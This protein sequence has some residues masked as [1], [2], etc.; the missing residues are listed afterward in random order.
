MATVAT[1]SVNF[2]QITN[3]TTD[4]A[5]TPTS[6]K[7]IN[8][9]TLAQ[10]CLGTTATSN[11]NYLGGFVKKTGDTMTGMLTLP[12]T[13]PSTDNHSTRKAYVDGRI[14]SLS[15]SVNDTSNGFVRIAGSTMTGMLTLPDISPTVNN[16]A[17]RKLYV[18]TR[19]SSLCASITDTSNGLGRLYLPLTGGTMSG[20]INMGNKNISNLAT[21]QQTNDAATKGYVDTQITGG[22]EG[23]AAIS[24]VNNQDNLRVLKAGDTMTGRLTINYNNPTICFQDTDHRSAFTH[25]NSDYFYILRG[26]D[27]STSWDAG[28]NGRHPLYLNLENGDATVSRDLYVGFNNGSSWE[29]RK[30]ATEQYVQDVANTRLSIAGGTMTGFVTLHAKPTAAKHAATKDYVDDVLTNSY[31]TIAYVNQ[32]DGQRVAKSGDTMSGNLVIRNSAPTIYFQDTDNKS[33]WI[34]INSNIFYIG[35][36]PNDTTRIDGADTINGR[37][38]FTVNLGNGNAV[39][40]G[41]VTAY[42][43]ERLKKNIKPIEN[44]LDKTL[45]L[46]GVTFERV[47]SG[48]KGLGLVA[49]K[50]KEVLPEVVT[51]D[52]DGYLALSYGNIVGLLV[53]AVK[54]LTNKVETLEAKLNS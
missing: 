51:E 1:I 11:L 22:T 31:A 53:E 54:E 15:A 27:N 48:D 3:T 39:A 20:V 36:A 32:Q 40:A 16:H 5:G 42:S 10:F 38:P 34:H 18:D 14:S 46:Q 4:F 44:A 37:W 21:P 12:S 49:Q 24:Y 2:A 50:V 30:V 33:S 41:D 23:F 52:K 7:S 43:D 17:A 9:L 47:Q 29:N 45:K 28:P 13:N 6:V 26:G 25:V 19:I 35:V 8:P